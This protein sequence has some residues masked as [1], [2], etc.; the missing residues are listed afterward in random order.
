ML[1]NAP[2]QEQENR[3]ARLENPVEVVE[4]WADAYIAR[5]EAGKPQREAE[6]AEKFVP[7]EEVMDEVLELLRQYE[8]VEMA[9]AKFR[10]IS[11]KLDKLSANK[12]YELAREMLASHPNEERIESLQQSLEWELKKRREEKREKWWE[13]HQAEIP[14]RNLFTHFEET[15]DAMAEFEGVGWVD[16]QRNDAKFFDK[17]W[18]NRQCGV[19]GG[20]KKVEAIQ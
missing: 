4:H 17:E 11:E 12:E 14:P 2:K 10:E 1:E 18:R 8:D 7:R 3:D 13:E 6:A 20:G 9:R 19:W 5:W 15:A 16:Q